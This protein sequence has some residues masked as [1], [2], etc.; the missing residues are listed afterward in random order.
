MIKSPSTVVQDT[1][2]IGAQ[3][4]GN[5]VIANV[6]INPLTGERST[7]GG[8]LNI[9]SLQDTDQYNAQ[10]K[11]LGFSVSIPIGAGAVGGSLSASSSKTK[12]NYQS[13]QEQAGIFAGDGGFQVNVNG[14]TDLKGAVIASTDKAVQDNKNSLTT[15]TLTTSNIEN[16]A[17]YKANASSATIGMG[18]QGGLPQ[19]SG[20]GIGH[21]EDKSNSVTVSAISQGAVNITDSPAQQTLTGK[22]GQLSVATLN[23]DVLIDKNGNAVDSQGNSPADTLV[24]I[25]DKE[26]VAKE[27]QA[28]VKITQAF[29]Q[30]APVALNTFVQEKT[31]PYTDAQKTI[32]ETEALLAK[33]NAS[34]DSQSA[35]KA[36]L[37]N[38]IN[39]AYETMA[40]TQD[41]YDNWKENGDY[42]IASNILI[43]AIS[44]GSSGVAS[45]VTK[46]SLSW[47]ADQMRQ[48]MIKD[49]MKF[50]GIC[51]SKTDCIS[52]M[53][54]ESVGVNGDDKKVAGGRV[55]LADWCKNGGEGACAS[56]TS[57][58][59]GYKENADGTVIFKP[60]DANGNSLTI[61]QFI[62]QHPE[63]RSPLGGHQGDQGQMAL[64]G[65]QFD[66]AAGSFWDKL[67]EAYSG[68]HDT[69][70]SF[71]WYDELG[72][73]KNLN[74]TL[75]GR[76][77]ATTNMTNV[78]VA[79]PFAYSVLLPPEVWNAVFTLIKYK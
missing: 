4:A 59:S 5:Q 31:K 44:G 11:S 37:Q 65:I 69:L 75:L 22:D 17:E 35:Y 43:A 56:D 8:N 47:A 46:E 54:G 34:D 2:V 51:T 41:D 28:Q 42:R 13:V 10:Q 72:N 12:S 52:N 68:T 18:R 79:T 49:S 36:E 23:R 66:Y 16:K 27:I 19:L 73:G 74:G 76:I 29:S 38:K 14:N 64:P 70:N 63:M 45:A 78:A 32:K 20:A 24:P 3:V 25:F 15:Q 61:S 58:L 71:I 67:A 77:G 62:D 60:V 7:T 55:I 50:P 6:G 26:K 1:N 40:G 48:A 9:Q 30:Q 33:V 39:Q 57:T 53:S 21:D